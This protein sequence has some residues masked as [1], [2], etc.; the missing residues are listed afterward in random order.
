MTDRLITVAE[1]AQRFGVGK[2][3]VYRE[4]QAGRLPFLK[5]GRATRIAESDAKAWLDSLKR[6]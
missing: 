5:V 6:H 4:H 2:S 1:F 3:T